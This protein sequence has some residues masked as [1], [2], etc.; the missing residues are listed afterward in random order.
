MCGR[1]TNKANP[2][3][4]KKEFKVG[5]L[6][7]QIFAAT[8][9]NIT[10]TQIIPVVIEAEGERII[11]NLKWGLIPSWA[12]DASIGSKMINA[13]AETLSEKLKLL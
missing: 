1:F 10:P 6:N 4:I 12:K 5:K 7:P 8:R 9:F 3:E 11:S 2:K 13:R